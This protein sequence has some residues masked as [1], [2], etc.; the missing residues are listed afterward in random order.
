MS[1]TLEDRYYKWR[2]DRKE[3]FSVYIKALMLICQND[4]SL[5]KGSE[6]NSQTTH[7]PD[8]SLDTD[9]N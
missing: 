4:K 2:A 7:Q 3:N 8:N 5:E 1:L 9:T 6:D